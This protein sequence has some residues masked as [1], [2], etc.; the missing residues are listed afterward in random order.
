MHKDSQERTGRPNRAEVGQAGR[1]DQPTS[2]AG[3]VP[4][5]LHPKDV[6]P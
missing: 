1:P 5:S 2:V 4:F 6:E 3:S